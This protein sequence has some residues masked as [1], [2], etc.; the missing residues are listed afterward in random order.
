ME[1]KKVFNAATETETTAQAKPRRSNRINITEEENIRL[2]ILESKK[3]HDPDISLGQKVFYFSE[4]SDAYVEGKITY[5]NK[6]N[7]WFMVEQEV[8]SV[9]SEKSS[10]IRECFLFADLYKLLGRGM[11]TVLWT[12]DDFKWLEERKKAQRERE[13]EARLAKEEEEDVLKKA[14]LANIKRFLNAIA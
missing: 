7:R 1:N 14:E 6:R 8:M 4:R 9:R 10:V 5:I 13:E 3:M 12:E 2:N 11:K